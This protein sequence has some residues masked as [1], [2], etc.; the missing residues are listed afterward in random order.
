MAGMLC[1]GAVFLVLLQVGCSDWYRRRIRNRDIALIAVG[2]AAWFALSG[3]T[4][5]I[6]LGSAYSVAIALTFPG[7]LLGRVGAADV[8][9]FCALA[10][11]WSAA[12]LLAIFIL[13]IVA[14]ATLGCLCGRRWLPQCAV[15]AYGH[16]SAGNGFSDLPLGT[17]M[18][19][20]AL[21][22]FL[23][24]LTLHA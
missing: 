5:Y 21:P 12:Q 15:P 2:S 7:F 19:T 1:L 6:N 9:L 3:P 24:R 22:W 18:M 10:P 4:A 13:G 17:V 23:W 8:K 11:L 14:V 16:G 20:G